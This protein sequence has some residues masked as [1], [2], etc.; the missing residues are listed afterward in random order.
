[1]ADQ[2]LAE[3]DV[4]AVGRAS[5]VVVIGTAMPA[6]LPKAD[7]ILPIANVVE[8]EGTLTNL[9]GRVQ[10]FL[11]AKATP[12]MA[13]PSWY[14]LA[15]LLGAMGERAE[16]H[17]AADAFAALAAGEPAFGG[18]SYD[19]L[20]LRGLPVADAAPSLAEAAR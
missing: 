8:E 20:G 18:L 5:V 10:R 9:R 14:V 2:D 6:N 13:R 3:H 15:D 12:G 19:S 4:A 17:T 16:Y 7:I 11:Q 1:V